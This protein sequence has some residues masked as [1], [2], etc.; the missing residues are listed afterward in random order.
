MS[1]RDDH[2]RGAVVYQIYPRS[3]RDSNGDGIG[4]LAG[5]V[6]TLPYIASLGVDAVW[7]SPFFASPMADFGYDVSDYRAVA[8]LFGTLADA[9][10]LIA[11][12]HRLGLK[13]LVDLVFAHTSAEHP[14]FRAS[15]VDRDGPH[16][17][18]YV[19]ADPR[20]DGSPPNNWLSV[21]GGGAWTW[22]PRRRQYYLHHFLAQQPKLN[23]RHPEVMAAIEDI[24][25]W[26]L[27]RGV[28]GFR[29]DAVDFMAHDP[30]LTDNPPHPER[31]IALRPYNMQLHV[32]DLAHADTPGLLARLR[33]VMD[34]H[35]GSF[36]IAEVGSEPARLTPIERAEAYTAALDG[37][38]SRLHMA[39]TLGLMKGTGSAAA[40]R[41]AIAE[42]EAHV[43]DGWLCW[44]FSNHDVERAA[45]RWGDGSPASARLLNALLLSLRG[46]VCVYQGEELGLTEA[47]V[48]ADRL[49]DPY[50]ITYHPHFKGRDGSRTPMPWRRD[51]PHAGFTD[52]GS[53][54]EP[55]LPVPVEHATAAVDVQDTDPT[56][57]L[58]G[59]R[60]F[61]AF[62][63]AHPALLRGKLDLLPTADPVLGFERTLDGEPVACLFNLSPQPAVASLPGAGITPLSGHGWPA[64]SIGADGRIGLPPWGAWFGR[65]ER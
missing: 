61:I 58:A 65:R 26:W 37:E 7:I 4:D 30:A 6:E 1:E 60:R 29:L 64:P 24:A 27:A 12:A 55:W 39:Y 33:Q 53:T 11:E 20:R 34:R 45:S 47:E 36:A 50:G 40:L 43:R 49:R 5:I 2:W 3:F 23:L 32:N 42:V 13:V 19:W 44:A 52:A 16:A 9:D 54:A 63:R 31:R 14:W 48:P 46:A 62:R 15:R 51:A 18:W 41:A 28:D 25:A 17:D 57:V 8:P 35:P 38:D 10:C 22:E 56:S 21:F 59:W